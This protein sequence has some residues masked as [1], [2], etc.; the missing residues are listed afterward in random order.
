MDLGLSGRV[1]LV[2][3]GTDGLG[4]AAAERLAEEGA[5]VA[6]CG[7][8]PERCASAEAA[9]RGAGEGEALAV[10]ADVTQ[11]ADVQ[12]F[13]EAAV[14][15][16]GRI[17]GLL[18]NAGTAAAGAFE[19]GDDAQWQA[20]FEQKVL[21]AVRPIRLALPHLRAAGDGAIVNVLNIGAKA[22]QAGTLPTTASRAAG[23][24]ITQA[25]SKELGAD[26]IRV[27]AILVGVMATRLWRRRAAQTGV[28]LDALHARLVEANDVALGR[29]GE[30]R[31]LADLAAFLLSARASYVT[32]AAVNLD[33]GAS[34][35]G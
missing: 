19:Q 21:G 22:P 25:L 14:E 35:V 18:N 24:A 2:T 5:R 33:G 12:R 30:P 8:D 32:G 29:M 7:R 28:A 26:G 34:P 23:L 9:L 16:W 20:D 4:L 6:V 27:N 31:E 17:D 10:A 13:V 15:R 3:G 1:V 11:P